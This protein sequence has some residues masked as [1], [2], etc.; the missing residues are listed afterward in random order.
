MLAF[1]YTRSYKIRCRCLSVDVFPPSHS[2]HNTSRRLFGHGRSHPSTQHWPVVTIISYNCHYF[3]ISFDNPLT[4]LCCLSFIGPY[5]SSYTCSQLATGYTA[6]LSTALWVQP[7]PP[8]PSH[9]FPLSVDPPLLPSRSLVGPLPC[10]SST[11]PH[12]NTN[13][14]PSKHTP[15]CI[16]NVYCT[17]TAPT[18]SSFF[19]HLHTAS[20]WG[21]PTQSRA[22]PP[23]KP[24]HLHSQHSLH[25][26]LWTCYRTQRPDRQPQTRHHRTY[27]NMDS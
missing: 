12:I 14:H 16:H 25:A 19:T 3:S 24:P 27:W 9:H 21:Y 11:L 22:H 8:Q 13:I 4:T 5:S 23:C 15:S 26:H 2:K 18:N 7:C 10:S 20:L 1:A 17:F 6:L